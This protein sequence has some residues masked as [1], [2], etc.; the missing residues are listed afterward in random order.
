MGSTKL[1]SGLE[2]MN[3]KLSVILP[4]IRAYNLLNFYEKL[5]ESISHSFEL[6]IVSPYDLPP[7][8]SDCEDI[9]Y[10]KDHGCPSRCQQIGLVHATGEYITWGA[11]DGFFLKSKLTEAVDFLDAN[12]TSHKDI[13]TCKYT[14][15]DAA[16][17]SPEMYQD[18]YY[19]INHSNGL[20]SQ[21]IP[22]DFW[23]LN[24]GV[25][26]TNYA[27]E[28]GGWDTQFEVTTISHM[29]FAVRAQRDGARFFMLPDPIF[30]CAHMPGT[31]GDHAPVHFSHVEHDEPL[32]RNIYKNP[33][34]VNRI[35]IDLNNWEQSSQI[36]R[37]RF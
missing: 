31:T 21:Y 19:K 15:G 27:K 5:E 24:V 36:W 35:N 10:I 25:I 30:S 23:I 29:D 33:A 37:R 13:V 9:K 16:A 20:R 2:K 22:D 28:L 34:S 1:F 12:R 11:D 18:I 3:C 32:F 6:I 26:N 7:A 8:L 17:M 4:S 14:E